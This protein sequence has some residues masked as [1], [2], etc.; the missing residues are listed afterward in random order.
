[1]CLEQPLALPGSINNFR[2]FFLAKGL[3]RQTIKAAPKGHP[4]SA[5]MRY[6]EE[7]SI[8]HTSQICAATLY[9]PP[10]VRKKLALR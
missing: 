2:G 6:G 10:V 9:I 3:H 8:S 5:D 1:M 7:D 4:P